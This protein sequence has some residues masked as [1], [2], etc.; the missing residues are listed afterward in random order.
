MYIPNCN[1]FCFERLLSSNHRS[2][3]GF[4]LLYNN[5]RL[6]RKLAFFEQVPFMNF[7]KC[8]FVTRHI[9][10]YNPIF[11]TIYACPEIETI[12]CGPDVQGRCRHRGLPNTCKQ[13][14]PL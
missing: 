9:L 4:Q 6:N 3:K 10:I 14:C 11:A 1:Y 8:H 12:N 13:I 2:Q 5:R 7:P